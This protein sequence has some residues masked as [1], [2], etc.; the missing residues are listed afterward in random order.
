MKN[1]T[2]AVVMAEGFWTQARIAQLKRLWSAGKSAA[3]IGFEL[4]GIS[5]AAVLGKIFRLRLGPA[6]RT[7]ARVK[8]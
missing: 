3:I 4:G 8:D 1:E 6:H 5:R 7:P 2:G